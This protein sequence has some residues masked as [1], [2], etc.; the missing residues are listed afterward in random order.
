MGLAGRRA[1]GARYRRSVEWHCRS[2]ETLRT[3]E[4]GDAALNDLRDEPSRAPARTSVALLEPINGRLPATP[5]IYE[6]LRRAIITLAVMPSEILSEKDLAQ[7]LG[8]SRTPVRE[9]LIRLSDEGLIDIYPQRGSFVA[10]IRLREVEEAQFIR[11]A[12]EVAVVRRLAERGTSSFMAAAQSNLAQQNEAARAGAADVFLDLDEKLHRLFC[13]EAGLPKSWR[14]IQTVKQQM[15]R[16]RFM[17]LPEAGHLQL[18]LTQHRGIVD[19]VDRGQANEAGERMS[20][21]LQE[22]I[23]T[24]RRLSVERPDLFQE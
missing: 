10:P 8:V 13:E 14:V 23:R 20:A 24:V 2:I 12:L 3:D 18:L 1:R 4:P 21:H 7:Q 9:A 15:D 6:R 19:A 22:V 17:S 5:Q 11:E 16:V